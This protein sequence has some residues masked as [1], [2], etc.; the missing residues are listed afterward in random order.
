MFSLK[1]R[2]PELMRGWYARQT[3]ET[4]EELRKILANPM[5]SEAVSMLLGSCQPTRQSCL[6]SDAEGNALRLSWLA[7]YNDFIRDI[8]SLSRVPAQQTELREWEHIAALTQNP[9]Q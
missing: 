2:A 4:L 1:P 7:G 8:E 6:S 5:F 3:P 9:P